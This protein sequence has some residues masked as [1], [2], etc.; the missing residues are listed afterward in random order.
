MSITITIPAA[1]PLVVGCASA[2]GEAV[3]EDALD[4]LKRAT[5]LPDPWELFADVRADIIAVSS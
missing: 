5:E 2:S 3:E 1:E 4:F